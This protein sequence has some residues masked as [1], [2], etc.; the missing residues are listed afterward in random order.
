MNTAA[1]PISDPNI[2]ALERYAPYLSAEDYQALLTVIH[3][4]APIAL[5]VNLLKSPDPAQA[6]AKWTNWYG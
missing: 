3:E 4:P 2:S 6:M 1:T 5:R